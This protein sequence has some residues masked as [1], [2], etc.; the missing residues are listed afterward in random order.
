MLIRL[1]RI[2]ASV[3]SL[4]GQGSVDQH[5]QGDG[6]S[7]NK[8]TSPLSV[9]GQVIRNGTCG[10]LFGVGLLACKWSIP[11]SGLAAAV[12]RF[13][14]S[15]HWISAFSPVVISLS[16]PGLVAGHQRVDPTAGLA[17]FKF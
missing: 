1:R 15:G 5:H 10:L 12:L 16:T 9:L 6:G 3:G 14:P 8:L 2:C 17:L 4:R 7:V 11:W 13:I